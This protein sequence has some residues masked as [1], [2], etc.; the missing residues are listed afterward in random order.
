ARLVQHLVSLGHAVDELLADVLEGRVLETLKEGFVPRDR[1][2]GLHEGAAAA[3]AL[4][5]VLEQGGGLVRGGARDQV[6]RQ[7]RG[8]DAQRVR[9]S[10]RHE[11]GDRD[12]GQRGEKFYRDVTH[13]I[14][15]LFRRASML[16]QS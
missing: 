11:G 13:C 12:E 8:E 14:I 10:R 5:Q 7:G 6:A 9:A 1:S 16:Y 2:L 3:R 15:P 4:E